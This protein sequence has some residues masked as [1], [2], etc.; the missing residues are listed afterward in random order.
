[1]MVATTR[2]DTR[3]YKN[4]H[5]MGGGGVLDINEIDHRQPGGKKKKK[6]K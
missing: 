4:S 1:M 6:E 5:M 3:P 2:Y